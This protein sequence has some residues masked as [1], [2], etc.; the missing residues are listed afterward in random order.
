MSKSPN[1]QHHKDVHRETMNANQQPGYGTS[2]RR[3]EPRMTDV[4]RRGLFLVVASA[5][6]EVPLGA[7]E[8]EQRHRG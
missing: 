3:E 7:G 2:T 1:I 6:L 4:Y 5:A 8:D